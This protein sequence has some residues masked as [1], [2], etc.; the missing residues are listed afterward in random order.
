[1]RAVT[2]FAWLF[3]GGIMPMLPMLAHAQ[4]AATRAPAQPNFDPADVYYQA[5]LFVREAET[6]QKQGRYAA[7]LERYQRAATFFDTIHRF[8]PEWKKDMV[9]DRLSLTQSQ[10]SKVQPLAAAEQQKKDVAIAEMVESGGDTRNVAPVEPSSPSNRPAIEVETARTKAMQA[11]AARTKALETEVARTKALEAEVARLSQALAQPSNSATRDQ[12]RVRDMERQRDDANVRLQQAQAD[13]QQLRNKLATAPVQSDLDRLN[14]RLNSLEQ[15]KQAMGMALSQSREQQLESQA[16]IQTLQ[17]DFAAARQQAAD[18]QRNLE[19]ERAQSNEVTTAQMQK[20]QELEKTLK[21]KDQ[22]IAQSHQQIA[23]LQTQ[24]QESR[25]AFQEL[26]TERDDLLRQRDHMSALLKLNETGRI[27]QLIEQNMSL[28]KE[29][30]EAKE[31]VDRLHKNQ[32]QTNDQLSEA[33]RDLA[34]AKTKIMSLQKEKQ[35]Q[36]ERLEELELQLKNNEKSLAQGEAA[37]NKEEADTLREII[38]RQLKVQERRKHAAHL[39]L[40]AAKKQM[41]AGDSDYDEA[42]ALLTDQEIT[43]SEEEQKLLDARQVDG[44]IYSP[45]AG[46]KARVD[47]ATTEMHQQI[48]NY[49]KAAVR[50]FGSQRLQA[51]R[52]VLE[53][54]LD[55]HPGHIA[56]MTKLGIV[57]LRLNDPAAAAQILQVAVENDESRSLSHRL[58]GLAQ[59]KMGQLAD[60]EK[61]LVRALEIDPQDHASLTIYGNTLVRLKRPAEAEQAYQQAIKLNPQSTEALHNLALICQKAGRP[62]DA[63]RYYEQALQFGA[64]PNP[65]L[66][67]AMAKSLKS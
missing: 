66:E 6:L 67:E 44:E 46:S 53:M 12:A 64:Q 32:E 47:A 33:L 36:Q 8:H 29:L 56:T 49:T 11:E 61:S 48:D 42:L 52:E 4:V 65:E 9:G 45:Y 27:Q 55:L 20:L 26:R 37:A 35:A 7:A 31:R 21:Q 30:R 41:T 5:W 59:Y 19:I 54:I 22:Q 17:A 23:A 3:L 60:A 62:K 40:Q 14:A 18:L 43:L 1:M 63:K 58:L 16:K 10:I 28:A 2:A 50:A 13:L 15:E 39:L 34:I 38:K 25:E 57:Q 24:L 51:S